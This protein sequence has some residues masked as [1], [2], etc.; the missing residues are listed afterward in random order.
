MIQN[1]IFKKTFYVNSKGVDDPGGFVI[2][3]DPSSGS[4]SKQD[5]RSG[6]WI[7]PSSWDFL[8]FKKMP[9][10]EEGKNIGYFIKSTKFNSDQA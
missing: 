1:I 6:S 8:M 3:S 7:W 2:S 10:M 5:Y 9:K 4:G